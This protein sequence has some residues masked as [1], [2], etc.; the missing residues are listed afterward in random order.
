MIK[1]IPSPED[2]LDISASLYFEAL[3]LL[4]KFCPEDKTLESFFSPE[5]GFDD[6]EFCELE[7]IKVG[8]VALLIFS[9]I[10]NYLKYKI[11]QHSPLLLVANLAEI[12]WKTMNYD[13]FYMHGFTDLLKLYA[14]IYE[15]TEDTGLKDAF[16]NLRIMRNKF[17]H[18]GR[19][20]EITLEKLLK[21]GAFFIDKIWNKNICEHGTIFKF[22][23]SKIGA[24]DGYH[25]LT[26]FIPQVEEENNEH[27]TLL[28]MYQLNSFFLTANENLSF[29]GLNKSE[30]KE[31]CPVCSIYDYLIQLKDYRFAKLTY[32][33][34]DKYISCNLCQAKILIEDQ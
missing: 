10:E 13:E 22:F 34:T 31:E 19:S 26:N 33:E 9:S 30:K 8:N 1:N 12:K 32:D 25:D 16:E 11:A 17:I 15:P 3:F 2:F 4:V 6:N 28:K 5:Y 29:I 18:S 23:S 21:V 24:L 27:E 14:V 7:S 20:K